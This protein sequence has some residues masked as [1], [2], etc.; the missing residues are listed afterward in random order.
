MISAT[1]N[2]GSVTI[3]GIAKSVRV[4]NAGL[5][6][7]YVRIGSGSQTATTADCPVLAGTSVVLYK[8]ELDVTLAHIADNGGTT[9]HVMTGDNGI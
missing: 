2:S 5:K 1:T 4:A 9:L 7:G 3:K 8:G 6:T